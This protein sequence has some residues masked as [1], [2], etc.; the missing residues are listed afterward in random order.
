MLHGDAG[1]Q[2]HPSTWQDG[3][4]RLCVEGACEEQ[5]GDKSIFSLKRRSSGSLVVT[6]SFLLETGFYSEGLLDGI[7]RAVARLKRGW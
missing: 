1:A 5:L 7:A 4:G 3:D 2:A 6:Q